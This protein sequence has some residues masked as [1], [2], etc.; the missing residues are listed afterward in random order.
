MVR[1]ARVVRAEQQHERLAHRPRVRRDLREGSEQLPRQRAQVEAAEPAQQH[2]GEP[3]HLGRQPGRHQQHGVIPVLRERAPAHGQD[4]HPDHRD[5]G[6]RGGGRDER[7][8]VG[9]LDPGEQRADPYGHVPTFGGAVQEQQQGEDRHRGAGVVRVLEEHL[10]APDD[11]GRQHDPGGQQGADDARP[12]PGAA[13]CQERGEQDGQGV[14]E[15][16]GDVHHV[17]A[18]AAEQ[19]HEHVL[20]QLGRV[21]GDVG[22]PPA[23]QQ[24]V[25]VQHRLGLQ[26]HGGAV[27]VERRGPRLAHVEREQADADQQEAAGPQQPGQAAAQPP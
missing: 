23:P 9:D 4:D 18:H 25:P 24:R 1:L 21:E 11:A 8:L 6:D 10:G 26:D 12:S 17:R 7:E 16:A 15:R 19:L 5:R 2:L 20:G 27:G 3:R 13:P 14:A 22:G